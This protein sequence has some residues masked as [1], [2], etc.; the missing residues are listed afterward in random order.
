MDMNKGNVTR[1]RG[2][3]RKGA[4]QLQKRKRKSWTARRRTAFLTELAATANVSHAAR[5]VD[6]TAQGAYKLRSR[7]PAFDAA[8]QAALGAGYERLE[9]QLLDRALNGTQQDVWYRGEVVGA[10]TAFSDGLALRLLTAHRSTVH[11]SQA[12]PDPEVVRAQIIKK[13]KDMKQRMGGDENG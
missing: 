12:A 4:P 6:M 1:T 13:L 9:L 2:S 10:R 8:W 7:D 3:G 11:K 5:T